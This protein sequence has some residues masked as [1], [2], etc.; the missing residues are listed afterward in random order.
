MLPSSSSSQVFPTSLPTQMRILSLFKKKKRHTQNKLES[1]LCW[2]ATPEHEACPGV[3]PL[4]ETSFLSP[5]SPPPSLPGDLSDLNLCILSSLCEVMCAFDLLS[6]KCC[7]LH[8]R[9]SQSLPLLFRT[10]PLGFE[11][12]GVEKTFSLGLSAPTLEAL[13]SVEG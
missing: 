4:K 7:F 10:D 3:T 1:S 9:L 2:R 6:G 13:F 11:R 5:R 8:H 12:S